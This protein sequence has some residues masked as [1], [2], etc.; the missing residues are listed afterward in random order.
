MEELQKVNE[1]SEKEASVVREELHNVKKQ[2]EQVRSMLSL[3]GLDPKQLSKSRRASNSTSKDMITDFN[4]TTRYRRRKQTE[5][6]LQFIHGGA[7]GSFYG[8]WDYIAADSPKELIDEFVSGYKGGKYLQ[9]TLGKAMK[10]FQSSPELN[11]H[12]VA[13]KYQNSLSR[14]KLNL[15]YKTQS[16]F[17]NG[18]NEAWIPRNVQRLGINIRLLQAVSDKVV[19]KFV[20]DL[21][22]G[23]CNQ[24]PSTLGV[25]RTVIGVVFMIMDL[26]FR[27]PHLAKKLTWFNELENHFIF[28]FSDDDAPETSQLTMSLGSIT[29]WNLGDRVRSRDYQYLLH[30]ASLSKKIK[31]NSA[32]LSFNRVLT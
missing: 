5:K 27:V 8:A 30:C 19:D 22:I 2:Y 9:E 18:E 24:I 20:K 29:L 21:N 32:G 28:E 6:A 14:R 31:V 4:S 1:A 23:H 26:H 7:T 13:M 17:F 11:K 25:T 16:S 12:A 15:V 10:E 3:L